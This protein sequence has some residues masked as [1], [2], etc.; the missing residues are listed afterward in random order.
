MH[1]EISISNQVLTL[2]KKKSII[3]RYS[4][5]TAKKGAGEIM[6]SECTPRGEHVIAEKIGEEA[7]E[8]SVFVG[9]VQTDESYDLQLRKLQPNRDWIL[10]RILWL[11]GI[12]DGKNKGSGLDSYERYIYIHG[13]PDDVE[14]GKPGSKGCVRMKNSDVIELFDLV[15]V[16]TRVTIS[17]K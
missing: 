17:E 4:V 6:N 8:N 13:S 16:G 3:K 1:I 10:T 2:Y 11:K 7:E 15:E 14:M 12:E 9:R 5:S